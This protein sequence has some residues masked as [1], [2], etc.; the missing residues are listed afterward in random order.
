M[1][2]TNLTLENDMDKKKVLI[3][4]QILIFIIFVGVAIVLHTPMGRPLWALFNH[5][6]G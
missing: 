5:L 2:S 4:L 6:R 3:G 1:N